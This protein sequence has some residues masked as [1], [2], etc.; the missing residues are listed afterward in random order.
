ML[1]S[2]IPRL[3]PSYDPSYGYGQALSSGQTITLHTAKQIREDV[4]TQ[5]GVPLPD[6]MSRRPG[7]DAGGRAGAP[8]QRARMKQH[9]GNNNRNDLGRLQHRGHDG[10]APGGGE[11]KFG[12]LSFSSSFASGL[13]S[14]YSG[15]FREN[16][17]DEEEEGGGGGG[18]F[19]DYDYNTED[20]GKFHDRGYSANGVNERRPGTTAQSGRS[21]WSKEE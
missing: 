14:D 11:G 16:P 10:A 12:A 9:H 15:S 13:P 2:S 19:N 4:A 5:R 6:L 7:D 20:N 18:G 1:Q 21:E 8:Q 17:Y 3:S